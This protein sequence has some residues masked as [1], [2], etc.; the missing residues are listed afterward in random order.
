ML[1]SGNYEWPFELVVNG[2]MAESIEGLADS[3]ITYKLKATVARGKLVYD[4]HAYKPL[5][6]VRT[7]DPAALELAHAMTV[8]NIWPN[9]IEYQL[10]IP[11]K[12]IVFGTSIPLEMRFTSLL[13]GLKIGLIKCVLFESQEFTLP[14]TTAS[15]GDK[16][17]KHT[18]AV[19][20]W[21]FELNDEEHYQDILDE[22]GQDGYYM[23]KSLPLPK[24]LSK[25]LQDA[26][27]CGIKIRHRVKINLA[28][29]NPD[30]HVSEVRSCCLT[31]R[32][33]LTDVAP[34]DTPCH[35]LYLSEHASQF[36]WLPCRPDTTEH[37]VGRHCFACAT[38]LWRAYSR[39]ALR[40]DGSAWPHNSS[41][42][43]R[44]EYTVLQ[45]LADW[46]IGESCLN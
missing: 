15:S 39:S 34:R 19:Q 29:H 16:Y 44:D 30:G 17:H 40:W 31:H 27:A 43:V 45:P 23:Q 20:A 25:C 8:E 12:A 18:R 42:A 11:Q 41:S 2:S 5:R 26:E 21:E 9:K 7:L 3:H 28:L 38:T 32:D 6:I 37:T 36:G 10:V 35:N 46:L 24:K 13:K 4:L 14:G 33:L 1:P 22:N